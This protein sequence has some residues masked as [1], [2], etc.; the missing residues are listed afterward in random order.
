MDSENLENE[1][2]ET[3]EVVDE[4]LKDTE[5]KQTDTGPDYNSLDP[6][7][8]PH[9]V[10]SG[11]KAFQGLLADVQS[12]RAKQQE[13]EQAVELLREELKDREE[14]EDIDPDEP[15]THAQ[16]E[17]TLSRLL[18]KQQQERQQEAQKEA[19]KKAAERMNRSATKL[20][21]EFTIEKTGEGL[22]AN[23]VINEGVPWLAVNEPELLKAAKSS[24][25]PARKVYELA[26]KFVPS[27]SERAIKKM[28]SKLLDSIKTGR[29]P[30]GGGAIPARSATQNA[31]V[32]ALNMS[33]EDL[34]SQIEQEELSD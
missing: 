17:K 24:D 29:I 13:L 31:I 4:A 18:S 14:K 19:I 34:L 21:K 10:I 12:G 9:A 28:N 3:P 8:I 15:I 22:D 25:D 20:E 30:K 33:D 2:E 5:E 27:I 7:K 26:V 11:T 23:T 6:A 16:L 1:M 32:E